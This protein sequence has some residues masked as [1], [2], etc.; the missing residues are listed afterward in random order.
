MLRTSEIVYVMANSNRSWIALN[1][2]ERLTFMP[3]VFKTDKEVQNWGWLHWSVS[4]VSQLQ[5]CLGSELD[6]VRYSQSCGTVMGQFDRPLK[7]LDGCLLGTGCTVELVEHELDVFLEE[8]LAEA[9]WQSVVVREASPVGVVL[10]SSGAGGGG[11]QAA[12]Q[13]VRTHIA[14]FVPCDD[15]IDLVLIRICQPTVFGLHPRLRGLA[16]TRGM[17]VMPGC[18]SSSS[19]RIY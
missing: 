4:L 5:D 3:L 14:S 1:Q 6:D 17:L 2:W 11:R 16:A 13:A 18:K 12:E 8:V 9:R 10:G 7:I 15:L 19:S